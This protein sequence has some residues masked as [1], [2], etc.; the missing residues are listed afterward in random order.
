LRIAGDQLAMN[1]RI[2][3]GELE[4][5][6]VGVAAHDCGV[7]LGHLARRLRQ[8][9]FAGRKARPLGRE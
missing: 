9:R 1:L 5:D 7:A 6:R 3:T 8:S 2:V 4:R